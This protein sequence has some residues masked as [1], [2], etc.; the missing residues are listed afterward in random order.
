LLLWMLLL[1]FVPVIGWC[2][3]TM[4]IDVDDDDNNIMLL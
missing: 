2:G 3:S 1:P 4:M